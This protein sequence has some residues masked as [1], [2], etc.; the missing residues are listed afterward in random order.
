MCQVFNNDLQHVYDNDTMGP[1]FVS[2]LNLL[3]SLMVNKFF[4]NWSAF[5]K[6]MGKYVEAL[7]PFWPI[8]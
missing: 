4:L 2:V 8:V 5:D 7:A 6:V 3:L 1:L